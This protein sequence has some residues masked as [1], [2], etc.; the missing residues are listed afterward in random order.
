MNDLSSSERR[1]RL[2]GQVMY[3]FVHVNKATRKFI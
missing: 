1:E 3:K 2:Y